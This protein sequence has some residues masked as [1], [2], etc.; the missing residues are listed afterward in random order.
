VAVITYSLTI[1]HHV[2]TERET[3][4]VAAVAGGVSL[5]AAGTVVLILWRV[6]RT[7]PGTR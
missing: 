4:L 1:T 3:I 6:L 2:L 5:V 7:K